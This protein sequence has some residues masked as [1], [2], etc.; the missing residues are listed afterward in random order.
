MTTAQHTPAPWR[1]VTDGISYWVEVN[2]KIIMVT[3]KDNVHLVAAAPDLLAELE[4]AVFLAE[5]VWHLQ[6]NDEARKI[7]ER[8]REAIAKARGQ[9]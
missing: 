3:G 1:V 4:H 6:G 5:S 9:S 7:A 2:N 8:G